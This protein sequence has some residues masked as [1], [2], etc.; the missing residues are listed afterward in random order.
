MQFDFTD[1]RVLV[2]GGTRGIG[3][4][5]VSAFLKA[6]AQVALNGRTAES[7]VAAISALGGGDKLCDASGNIATASGC[8]AVVGAAVDKMGGL[9]VLIN[10]A[11][12]AKYGP[13][14]DFD[15]AAWDNL[16]DINLKGTFFA[17]AQRWRRCATARAMLSIWHPT[18]A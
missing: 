7:T 9:D 12:V 14:E 16:L 17:S 3:R 1:K 11:G 8:E 18:P 5:A 4:G 10:C 2:T 15:E 13:I 6:G